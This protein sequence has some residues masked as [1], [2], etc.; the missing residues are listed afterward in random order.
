MN[1]REGVSPLSTDVFALLMV[2]G[3]GNIEAAVP[4][5]S[6]SEHSKAR[7]IQS[8]NTSASREQVQDKN[9]SSQHMFLEQ[10]QHSLSNIQFRKKSYH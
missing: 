8:H 4:R 9:V 1:S 5:I 10:Q 6:L 3:K 7:T 2:K